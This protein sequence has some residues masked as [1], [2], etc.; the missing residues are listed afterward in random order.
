[1]QQFELVLK[2]ER[3][4]I[5]RRLALFIILL[6]LAVFCLLA[7]NTTQEG[8]REKCIAAAVILIVFFGLSKM[9]P[10]KKKVIEFESTSL[11]IISFTWALMKFWPPAIVF[12]GIMFLYK[13][14]QRL[15]VVLVSE[16]GIAYPSFPKKELAWD[17]LNNLLL[18]DGLLT[19]DLK[20]NK[21]AQVQVINGENNDSI[22]EK[23]FN[24]FC[25]IQLDTA[26]AVV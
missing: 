13:I 17:E 4:K 24:E 3:V 15:L 2:N 6:N 10:N 14:S 22:D 16:K 5:Y 12:L 25:Q 7:F 26:T 19:V 21:L 20:N 8:I 1:M 11:F 18:K 9:F 23:E